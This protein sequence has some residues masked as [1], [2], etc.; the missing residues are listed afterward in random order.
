MSPPESSRLVNDESD[1]EDGRDQSAMELTLRSGMGSWNGV[2]PSI[3]PIVEAQTA[4]CA[5]DARI[6]GLH[7]LRFLRFDTCDVL[8]L[9]VLNVVQA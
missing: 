3:F 5:Y 1:D 8:T 7:S 6:R 9:L 4:G 2:T